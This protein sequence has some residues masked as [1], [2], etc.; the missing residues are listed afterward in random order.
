MTEFK[1]ITKTSMERR[2]YW[3]NEIIKLSGSF[4]TDS[5][6]L[7]EELRAEIA[8]EGADALIDHLRLCGAI[9]EWY[10][11][12]SSEEKLYSKYT[13][14]ILNETFL[15]LGLKS[16][17]LSARGD[18]ADVEAVAPNYSLVADAKAF[19]L[20]RTAKNQKDFKVQAMNG[21]RGKMDHALVVCPVYQLP[22]RSSQIYEQAAATHVTIL[23]YS[24]LAALVSLST[25]SGQQ[26]GCS[27]L[28]QLLDAVTL[29]N[30]SKDSG[31]YWNTIN[32]Q[33]M[34]AL[35]KDA[36]E[37][38]KCEKMASLESLRFG[39]AEA[40][41]YLQQERKRLMSLSHADAIAELVRSAGVD[42]RIQQI[43]KLTHGSL[44]EV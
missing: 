23:T 40:I 7:E 30:P 4:G 15:A 37:I 3:T 22:T 25:S 21:W 36:V 2:R 31:S 32:A 38:W 18:S 43:L 16:V 39:Q 35:G 11:H 20:S 9:P 14:S 5:A 12:D 10:G 24:H 13:D 19:R 28:K 42:E 6:K 34:I 41:Q 17:V 29:M 1:Y 26:A 8:R 33:L 44:L 27:G